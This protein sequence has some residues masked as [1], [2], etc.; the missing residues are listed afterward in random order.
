MSHRTKYLT[1]I[2]V[3]LFV[4][5][6][7]QPTGILKKAKKLVQKFPTPILGLG[8]GL[9]FGKGST[10]DCTDE[11]VKEVQVIID[12]PV[13]KTVVKEV[14][15]NVIKEEKY[16][17]IVHVDRPVEVIKHVPIERIVHVDRP[18]EVIKEE[19][20]DVVSTFY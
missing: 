5:A 11:H 18:V 10:D 15:V 3:A 17:R 8:G 19:P 12:K 1:L 13:Y 20:Y 7:A 2:F 16:E 4:A 6:N 9:S 14:P